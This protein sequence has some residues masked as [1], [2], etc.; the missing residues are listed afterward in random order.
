MKQGLP[1][2]VNL[3]PT[4]VCDCE[5]VDINRDTEDI[6]IYNKIVDADTRG[7][8]SLDPERT[9]KILSDKVGKITASEYP[10]LHYIAYTAGA[11]HPKHHLLYPF[12]NWIRVIDYRDKKYTQSTLVGYSRNDFYANSTYE[13]NLYP[14]NSL[15]INRLAPKSWGCIGMKRDLYYLMKGQYMAR[16]YNLLK[17]HKLPSDNVYIVKAIFSS[18]GRGTYVVSTQDE[19]KKVREIMLKEHRGMAVVCKYI[20]NPVLVSTLDGPNRKWHGRIY[21][22]ITSWGTAHL[23]QTLRIMTAKS[24]YK[25]DDWTNP[26]IH[27]THLK[28]TPLDY[29]WPFTEYYLPPIPIINGIKN[30]F[31]AIVKNYHNTTDIT[32][33]IDPTHDPDKPLNTPAQHLDVAK[34]G[35]E[36][37]GMDILYDENWHPWLLEVNGEPNRQMKSSTVAERFDAALYQFEYRTCIS[38]VFDPWYMYS[39]DEL[40]TKL[41]FTESQIATRLAHLGANMSPKITNIGN[42]ITNYLIYKGNIC[43]ICTMSTLTTELGPANIGDKV[44]SH[45]CW[46]TSYDYPDR[47]NNQVAK[48]LPCLGQFILEYYKYTQHWLLAKYEYIAN[49]YDTL[50]TDPIHDLAYKMCYVSSASTPTTSFYLNPSPNII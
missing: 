46:D 43:G 12:R 41:G 40:S 50:Y 44:I 48:D 5:I 24:E 34:Y 33:I 13:T 9:K 10:E 3:P 26:D 32:S 19:Y 29:V 1:Y 35:Y 28:S 20:D 15:L 6:P 31:F 42:S 16:S 7:I 27:D 22:Y 38:R 37:F 18:R 11:N 25:R 17:T 2:V 8:S 23:C 47:L 49:R 30:V 39:H 14:V 21:F 45:I 36:L 4:R